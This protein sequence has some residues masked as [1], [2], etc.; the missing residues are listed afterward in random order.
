MYNGI[1]KPVVFCFFFRF[2]QYFKSVICKL[3]CRRTRRQS[4]TDF[5][6][7]LQQQPAAAILRA[8]AHRRSSRELRASLMLDRHHPTGELQF[9]SNIGLYKDVE[10]AIVV[11]DHAKPY[12]RR[13]SDR[14][15][16]CF[17]FLFN[18]RVACRIYRP[19]YRVK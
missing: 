8:A 6:G 9:L 13:L 1:S 17:F 10:L 11:M 2:R 3:F 12:P 18:F 14:N 7:T 19:I 16:Q 15:F 5:G 4:L